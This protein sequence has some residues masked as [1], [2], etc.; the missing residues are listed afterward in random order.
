MICDQNQFSCAKPVLYIIYIYIYYIYCVSSEFVSSCEETPILVCHF[1][2]VQFSDC[3]WFTRCNL[4]ALHWGW[5]GWFRAV[6][7]SSGSIQ[8][9]T[10]TGECWLHLENAQCGKELLWDWN[11]P[12]KLLTLCKSMFLLKLLRTA[13]VFGGMMKTPFKVKLE[14]WNINLP[15]KLVSSDWGLCFLPQ[16][17]SPWIRLI[18]MWNGSVQ[19]S[20]V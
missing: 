10:G 6:S 14:V 16:C 9:T 19:H 7:L 15:E 13:L 20:N 12:F 11:P 2:L 4:W 18:A 5:K 1:I 17:W 3:F 8:L